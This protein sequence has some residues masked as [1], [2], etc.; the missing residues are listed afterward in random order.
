[1]SPVHD[2]GIFK[3][4]GNPVLWTILWSYMLAV[5]TSPS[6]HSRQAQVALSRV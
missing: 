3:I 6:R 5:W 4:Q 2:T 1:M